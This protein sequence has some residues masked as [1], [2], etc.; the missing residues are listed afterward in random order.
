MRDP[1]AKLWQDK[2]DT[3]WAPEGTDLR[4]IPSGMTENC[5]NRPE[6]I[7]IL[8]ICDG[9]EILNDEQKCS[10]RPVEVG[11]K[12]DLGEDLDILQVLIST[13]N[14]DSDQM[15]QVDRTGNSTKH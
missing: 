12:L 3:A 6:Q 15:A 14:P 10:I 7:R 11:N 5:I 4:S 1:L 13:H 8:G 9:W 2:Y